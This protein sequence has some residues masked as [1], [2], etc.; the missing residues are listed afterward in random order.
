LRLGIVRENNMHLQQFIEKSLSE[1]NNAKLK[2]GCV[3]FEIAVYPDGGNIFV[4]HR[5]NAPMG[6]TRIKFDVKL[7]PANPKEETD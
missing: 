3:T 2:D 1:F 4:L 6:L 7:G 5:D